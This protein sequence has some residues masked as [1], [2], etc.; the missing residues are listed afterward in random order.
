M[1]INYIFTHFSQMPLLIGRC[2]G[3]DHIVQL[4]FE[5]S[6]I[7]QVLSC[8][9]LYVQ[10]GQTALYIA[11]KEGHTQVAEVLLSREA[12]VNHQTKV[13]LILLVTQINRKC[14]HRVVKKF[15]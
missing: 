9:P 5:A 1:Y 10:D 14:Y 3:H 12:N 13:K 6:S 2:R 8:S 15:N 7:L 4:L 11:A